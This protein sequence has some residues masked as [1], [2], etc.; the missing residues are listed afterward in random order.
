MTKSMPPDRLT[1]FSFLWAIAVLFHVGKWNL[2][3]H[4]PSTFI[5]AASAGFLLLKPSSLPR[6]ITVLV[7]QLT[8]SVIHMPWIP[9]HWL[10][11]TIVNLSILA[12]FA[13]QYIKYKGFNYSRDAFYNTFAPL[14]RVEM[15]LLYFIAFFHK[16]NAD[17]LDP[18][19]S[20]G[21]KLYALMT[22]GADFLQNPLLVE[23]LGIYAPL[24]FE[25]A[26]PLFLI[27]P[28]LRIAGIIIA[29]V[30]HFI[31]GI[32]EY[33]NF[34][35]I[36]FALLFLF[37]P[38]N[39]MNTFQEWR[40]FSAVGKACNKF[41]T[42]EIFR[43]LKIF[44]P[45]VVYFIAAVLFVYSLFRYQINTPSIQIRELSVISRERLYY[46]YLALW[47]IYGVGVSALFITLALR[48]K[49]VWSGMKQFF[50]PGY[51][52]LMLLPLLV[53]INGMSPYLGLKTQ[54]SWSMFSNLRTE[55]GKTNHIL[56][57]EPFYIADFQNDLVEIVESSDPAL[58]AV[59]NSG[60]FFPYFEF[61][62]YMS[63][64]KIRDGEDFEVIYR[65]GG[66]QRS[67]RTPGD[68]PELFEPY[69]PITAKLLYFRPVWKGEGS[70]CQH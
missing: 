12:A 31:L 37:A 7:I 64:K 55:G 28:R 14:V 54:T 5:L 17:W 25:L 10:F 59:K 34:S 52:I 51:K 43:K 41:V 63:T 11:T 62:R 45:P 26:I 60:Y 44:L 15:I 20:C 3:L 19:F 53:I 29:L 16:L 70:V 13:A 48:I 68:D 36:M 32:Q 66:I 21:S 47:W 58:Q 6:L 18:E 49:P 35:A 23:P 61:R 22:G 8:D 69:N 65:R 46:L 4:S 9:N 56:F 24:A 42:T 39:F 33:F 27:I 50:L 1:A 67:V 38:A 40:D 2:W 30:F 57:D